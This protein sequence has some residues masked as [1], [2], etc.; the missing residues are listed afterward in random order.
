MVETKF[1]KN[2]RKF[3]LFLDMS[4]KKTIGLSKN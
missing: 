3:N 2:K 1:H 4:S